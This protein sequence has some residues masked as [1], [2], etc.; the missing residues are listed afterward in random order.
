MNLLIRRRGFTLLELL[1]V[2][3]VLSILASIA[4]PK[5]SDML[6]KAQEGT[7]KGDLGAMRTALSL[8]YNDNQGNYPSCSAGPNSGVLAKA[9]V[10]AYMVS[11][12][13]VNNGL[14]PPTNSV[15]CDALMLPG[16]VH[17]GQGWYYDG[18][19]LDSQNG[20]I[21]VACDHTDTTGTNW[22]SY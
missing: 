20:G 22:S 13:I 14:H 19:A 12:P 7:L 21:W 5:F 4:L 8:Y 9:L 1:I 11:I 15:Y 18:V 10:P 3:S 2:F 17:D 16:D 6:L